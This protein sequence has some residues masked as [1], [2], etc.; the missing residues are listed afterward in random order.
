MDTPTTLIDRDLRQEL[1]AAG[2]LPN[3]LRRALPMVS[4]KN[5]TTIQAPKGGLSGTIGVR[6]AVAEFKKE[7]PEMFASD[8]YD[9]SKTLEQIEKERDSNLRLRYSSSGY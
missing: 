9:T 7:R 8:Y 4:R 6:E 5:I 3:V 2:I 1:I